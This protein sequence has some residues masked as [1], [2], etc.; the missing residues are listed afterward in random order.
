[1]N[2]LLLPEEVAGD[3]LLVV[4]VVQVDIEHLQL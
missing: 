3:V 2:I 4:V 1:L